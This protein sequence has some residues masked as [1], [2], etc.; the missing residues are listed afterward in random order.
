MNAEPNDEKPERKSLW[1]DP[2]SASTVI[3]AVVT[4][5]FAVV[6][7]VISTGDD[8]VE[9]LIGK[10]EPIIDPDNQTVVSKPVGVQPKTEPPFDFA[11][12]THAE[13]IAEITRA[14][15]GDPGAVALPDRLDAIEMLSAIVTDPPG[16]SSNDVAE[17]AIRILLSYLEFAVEERRGV[18]DDHT[19][20]DT[21]DGITR[22]RDESV[23]AALAVLQAARTSVEPAASVDIGDIDFSFWNISF[24]DLSGFDASHGNFRSAFLSGCSAKGTNFNHANLREA[25][26][27]TENVSDFSRASFIGAQISGSKWSNVDMTGSTIDKA[28]GQP[29]NWDNIRPQT[30][31]DLFR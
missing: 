20:L 16:K 5:V 8:W 18:V 31:Q 10:Q 13:R 15:R 1:S 17:Q 23:M 30:A 14:L 7:V 12:P 25:V 2:R 22:T 27:W 28:I 29:I 11:R 9:H 19:K 21:R 26:A 4:G 6:T 24:C 3:A